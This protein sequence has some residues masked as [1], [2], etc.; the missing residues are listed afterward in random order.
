[1]RYDLIHPCVGSDPFH[2]NN[3]WLGS[4]MHGEKVLSIGGLEPTERFRV[5]SGTLKEDWYKSTLTHFQSELT[6]SEKIENYIFRISTRAS[7]P[8]NRADS[9]ANQA[10]SPTNGANSSTNGVDSYHGTTLMFCFSVLF[11]WLFFGSNG[12]SKASNC[13]DLPLSYLGRGT[14]S[15]GARKSLTWIYQILK[16]PKL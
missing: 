9:S 7:S 5:N 12:Y 1:M 15:K 16:N 14:S 10:D 8:S 6:Y 3:F 11:L 4:N 13:W 2:Y